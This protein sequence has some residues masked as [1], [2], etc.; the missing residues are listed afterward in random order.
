LWVNAARAVCRAHDAH[1]AVICRAAT[2]KP[3]PS[4]SGFAFCGSFYGLKKAPVPC[5]TKPLYSLCETWQRKPHPVT[6]LPPLQT[7]RVSIFPTCRM[8]MTC[9]PL[10]QKP[11]LS[12]AAPA[13]FLFFKIL[14]RRM[15]G[16]F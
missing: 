4:R 15:N 13:I 10:H 12:L 5:A 9:Q 16:W 11:S 6:Y 8:N 1:G 7:S 2:K 14:S 3:E